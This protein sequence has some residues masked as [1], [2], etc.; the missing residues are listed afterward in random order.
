MNSTWK[1]EWRG[2]FWWIWVI[3]EVACNQR[4][5][6]IFGAA[7]VTDGELALIK[8]GVEDRKEEENKAKKERKEKALKNKKVGLEFIFHLG[9]ALGFGV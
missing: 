9:L 2:E 4:P 7:I 3:G 1:I 5:L 6:A 8:K